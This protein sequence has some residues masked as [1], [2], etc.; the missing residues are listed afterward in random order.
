L[1]TFLK[2][3]HSGVAGE[4]ELACSTEEERQSQLNDVPAHSPSWAAG[5]E[6]VKRSAP[7]AR[8]VLD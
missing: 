4:I 2:A 1:N 7:Q 6:G 3:H 8:M 5:Q